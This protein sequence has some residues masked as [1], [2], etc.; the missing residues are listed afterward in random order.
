MLLPLLLA[1]AL[2]ATR[3]AAGADTLSGT[4]QVTGEVMGNPLNELCTLKQAGT[5][6]TGSCKNTDAADAKPFDVTGDVQGGKVAFSHPGD[7]QGQPLTVSYAGILASA[8]AFK[9]TVDVQPFGV[10]GTFT[11]AAASPAPAAATKP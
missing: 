4:W 11:A 1:T 2:H 6:L 7:Y 8:K 5:K 9:G 10:S 3:A